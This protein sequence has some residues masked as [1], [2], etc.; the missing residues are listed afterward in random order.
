MKYLFWIIPCFLLFSTTTQAQESYVR[1]GVH[2]SYMPEFTVQ[3]ASD[4]HVQPFGVRL[5]LS[6]Y[7]RAPLEVG[8]NAYANYGETARFSFG[9]S[10]AY[11][12]AEWTAHDFKV[13]IGI[14][15]IELEDVFLKDVGFIGHQVGDVEFDGFGNE[16]KPYIEWEWLGT[17]FVTLFVQAG[18]RIINGEKTVVTEV[19]EVFDSQLNYPTTVVTDRKSSF[20]YSGA[21]FEIGAG[22]SIILF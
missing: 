12:L 19:E 7:E 22:I 10:L 6:D 21:G 9:T 17:R 20:F 18:Y 3:E 11:L 2:S 8:I 5:L 4:N 14:S 1:L 15:K 13:G 16:F